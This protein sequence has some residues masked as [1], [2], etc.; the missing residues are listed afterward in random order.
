MDRAIRRIGEPGAVVDLQI[1]RILTDD[2]GKRAVQRAVF[3]Q[4]K[5][6]FVTDSVVNQLL[7]REMVS[8]LIRISGTASRIMIKILLLVQNKQFYCST[9]D[10]E[11]QERE[12]RI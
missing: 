3:F 11:A 7:R 8:P 12:N 6:L 2:E 1:R 9:A 5:K 10:D 4:D